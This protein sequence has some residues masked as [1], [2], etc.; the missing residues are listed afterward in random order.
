[1]VPVTTPIKND[2]GVKQ[3]DS[4]SPTLFKKIGRSETRI[5]CGGYVC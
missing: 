4:L 5:A 3:G 2:K 1:M